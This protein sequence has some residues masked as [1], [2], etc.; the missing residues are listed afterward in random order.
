MV[1]QKDYEIYLY[2]VSFYSPSDMVYEN[3]ANYD[4]IWNFYPSGNSMT[5]NGSSIVNNEVCS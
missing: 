4:C 2:S 1:I 5:G 3:I